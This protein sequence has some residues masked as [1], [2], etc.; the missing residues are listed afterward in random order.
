MRVLIFY[1][2][3]GGGHKRAATALKEYI[4]NESRDNVV[5]A[6]DGLK[7]TG[8]LYNK[9]ICGGYTTL[10]KTMP[11]FYGKIYRNSDKKSALNSLCNS[12]NKSKGRHLLPIINEFKPDIIISCHAFITTMLGNL[13]HKGRISAQVIAL[14]TDFQAHYTYIAEGVDHYI[15][16]SEKMVNDFKAKYNIDESRVHAFGIPVFQKFSEKADKTELQKKLGLKQGVKT[17]LFMA[18]SFG[19]SEV[20]EV[21]KDIS[22]KAKDCQFVVITGNNEHLYNNFKS[23]INKSTSLLMFINNVEDYMRCADLI[24]TKPG[25]LTVSESLTCSL[26][27]AIYSAF[28]GQEAENAQFLESI[29][30]AV[31][32]D[33]NEGETISALINDSKALDNMKNNCKKFYLGNSSKLICEF[34][35]SL[36]KRG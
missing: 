20:L 9:F 22:E 5:E 30:V 17:I 36:L 4:D 3:T 13:K 12:I 16:N 23:L 15:A 14:I 2:S 25:G 8:K 19:V 6:V 32:L 27:M 34:A 31:N 10:A 35:H 21:Y 33:K 28:P 18:G 29:G 11:N 1:A 26:P 7:L 24:I